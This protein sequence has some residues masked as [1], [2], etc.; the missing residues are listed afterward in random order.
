M[1]ELCCPLSEVLVTAMLL[2][3]ADIPE[4][5]IAVFSVCEYELSDD[6]VFTVCAVAGSVVLTVMTI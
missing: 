1:A 6:A 3:N 2:L 4:L 5:V